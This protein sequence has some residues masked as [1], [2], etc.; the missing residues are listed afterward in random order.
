MTSIESSE[1]THSDVKVSFLVTFAHIDKP[2]E[3]GLDGPLERVKTRLTFYKPRLVVC[4]I[5]GV[6][7]STGA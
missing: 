5:D 3:S 2:K 1:N 6:G 7:P 4:E